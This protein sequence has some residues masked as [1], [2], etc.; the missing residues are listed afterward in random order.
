M[1]QQIPAEET[2]IPLFKKEELPGIKK[3][4]P[5]GRAAKRTLKKYSL[6]AGGFGF[7][8]GP[9]AR[10]ISIAALLT[11][12]LNDMSRIYG[13]SFSENQTKILISAILGG[14]HAHW[15]NRYLLKVIRY[16]PISI[17]SANIL[18]TPVVTSSIVYYIGKL[19]LIHF[20]T[21]AWINEVHD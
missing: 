11:K 14:V 4:S 19:F 8:T 6:F 7:I 21:G 17:R 18:L 20:E 2:Q 3:L 13:Q 10:Q 15:I 16:T 5:K 12:L 9:F 1:S